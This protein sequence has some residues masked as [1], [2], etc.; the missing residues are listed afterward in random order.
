MAKKIDQNNET[1]VGDFS[2]GAATK[3]GETFVSRALNGIVDSIEK[4]YGQAKVLFGQGFTRYLSNATKR[5]NSVKTIATGIEPRSIIGKDNIYVNIGVSY[6][7]KTIGTETVEPLLNVSKNILIFGT[8]GIGKS[9]L[10]RY[11]FLNTANRGDYV[12]VLL[13][14][15]KISEQGA[16]EL[17]V[18]D[19]IYSCM[20]NFDVEL[21]RDQFEYSLRLGKYLFLFDGLDE[22]KDALLPE[23]EEAIQ[24]FASRYPNNPCIITSRPRQE[25]THL[26]TFI[27]ISAN[28]LSKEQAICMA[29]KI[30][31]ED[32]KTIEFCRQLEETLYEKH[33]SFAEIPLLLSMMGLTFMRNSSIPDHLAD[34]YQKAY[35]A[36]YSVH[37]GQDKGYFHREFKCKDLDERSFTKLW[38]RFCFQTYNDEKYEFERNDLLE[39]LKRSI[40]KLNLAVKEDDFLSDLRNVVCM[41]VEDGSTFKFSHR[42]F[43]TYFAAVYTVGLTDDQQKKLFEKI[44]GD[45]FLAVQHDEFFAILF[46]VEHDRFL[47]NAF[48]DTVSDLLNIVNRSPHPDIELLKAEIDAVS[49]EPGPELK[50]AKHFYFNLGTYNSI[51]KYVNTAYFFGRLSR[52]LLSVPDSAV[53][54]RCVDDVVQFIIKNIEIVGCGA[55]KIPNNGISFKALDLCESIAFEDKIVFYNKLCTINGTTSLRKLMMN[56]LDDVRRKQ[57]SLSFAG[58]VDEL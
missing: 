14:L 35:E 39:Y 51:P 38:A 57:E 49:L 4:K 32:E 3:G 33:K 15:R 17:S 18:I 41:I 37:D 26:E 6:G 16:G 24:L 44:F 55:E 56:W 30:W 54:T 5:Y 42:S 47:K 43:Q 11:F 58:F 28:T 2:K 23:A 29:K 34:F 8:G 45:P 40:Q 31:K 52:P 10:M 53:M 22:V 7:K 50:K 20:S 25:L 27:P 12:P 19:L 1:F 13:E 36:L 46:Q 21:P 48:E 9:M